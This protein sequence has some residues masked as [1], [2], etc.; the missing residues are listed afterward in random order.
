MLAAVMYHFLS[1]SWK[2]SELLN[3]VSSGFSL[4]KS[5]QELIGMC[6]DVNVRKKW[7]LVMIK[8][9][10]SIGDEQ[11]F[12]FLLAQQQSGLYISRVE[13]EP[14]LSKQSRLSLT[15][16]PW[17]Y[18]ADECTGRETHVRSVTHRNRHIF[19]QDFM[20][21][22]QTDK[23]MTFPSAQLYHAFGLDGGLEILRKRA[24][25]QKVDVLN[26]GLSRSGK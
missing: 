21:G 24:C 14:G 2:S 15:Y 9:Y 10:V 8:Y 12:F 1:L 17:I 5:L 22:T 16:S 23:L 20:K 25:D 18:P 6:R 13:N 4:A 19:S 26:P 3:N 11:L 7:E